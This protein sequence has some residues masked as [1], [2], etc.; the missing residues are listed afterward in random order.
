MW[1]APIFLGIAHRRSS[2]RCSTTACMRSYSLFPMRRRSFRRMEPGLYAGGRWA[3]SGRPRLGRSAAGNYALQARSCEEFIHLLTDSLPPRPEY[4][5]RE[6]ELNRQGAAPLD[7]LP[8]PA[9]VRAPEVF[10]LQSAGAI[11]LDTR[12]AMQ[13]AVAHVPGSFHI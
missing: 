2:R 7:Q 6:V 4:F 8:P 5:G 1:A 3:P 12:P 11:V 9:P 13:F 10:R